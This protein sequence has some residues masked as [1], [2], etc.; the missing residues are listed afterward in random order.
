[1][2]GVFDSGF[3]G[4]SI[5]RQIRDFLPSYDFIYLGDSRRVPYGNRSPETVTEWSREAVE[6]L[7][8]MN[9]KLII[10][11]CH[12]AS[13]VALRTLQQKYLPG[14]PYSD[15]RILG[16]TIPIVEEVCAVAREKVGVLATRGTCRSR[17]FE[18]EI[19]NRREDLK[20][21]HHE[22]PLLVPLIE[23]GYTSGVEC[24]RILKKYLNPLKNLQVDT[25]VLGCTHYPLI[26]DLVRHKV[27]KQIKVPDPA[28]IVAT[29]LCSYLSRHPEI[30]KSLSKNSQSI[31]MTTDDTSH[32]EKMGR[33]FL[34]ASFQAQR[35]DLKI[36]AM[37]K[38]K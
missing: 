10:I 25:L 5:F 31:F 34:G 38:A 4:L 22:A 12:T 9:C 26:L 19:L 23:E 17:R 16:V 20:V 28:K 35:V 32:F 24:T 2:I 13:N 6:F 15:L 27:G 11:A 37:Q 30:E 18:E 1:M 3:G 33:R 21:F 29:S 36:G 14:S 7:F 8:A